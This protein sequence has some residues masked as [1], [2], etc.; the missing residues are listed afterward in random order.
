[1]NLTETQILVKELRQTTE[2]TGNLYGLFTWGS[3]RLLHRGGR[4]LNRE[5][6]LKVQGRA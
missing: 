4:G 6:E 2:K 3:G 1:M 5:K